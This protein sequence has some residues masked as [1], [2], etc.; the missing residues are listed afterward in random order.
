M[1]H[2]PLKRSKKPLRQHSKKSPKLTS[3][4]ILV[5][6]LDSIFSLYIRLRD[7]RKY[8]VCPFCGVEPIQQCFHMITRCKFSVRWDEQNA[9]GS[10][11]GC[12]LKNE[13][14]PASFI[15]WYVMEF[16]EEQWDDLLRRSNVIA[17]FSNEDLK[18]LLVK[19]RKKLEVQNEK[20]IPME[21][22]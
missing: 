2:T 18:E 4:K 6:V 7:I 5:A 21:S 3:R 15:R 19:Y 1:K 14:E 12:N 8:K 13:Y 17:K 11:S 20:S 22:I 16:G 9:V 10:C